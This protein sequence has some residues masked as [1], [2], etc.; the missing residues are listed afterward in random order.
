[1]T[2]GG[3]TLDTDDVA[4][5]SLGGDPEAIDRNA[6]NAFTLDLS[7]RGENVSIEVADIAGSIDAVAKFV[8][9]QL[10]RFNHLT[11]IASMMADEMQ[12][13]DNASQ[14]ASQVARDSAAQGENS[15]TAV[16]KAVTEIR[17]LVE[18][19]SGIE[20]RLESLEQSLKGVT[21]IADGIQGIA[22]QT[23][24]LA[25]NATIEAA[26]AG[27]AGKGF[28]VV[29]SEV[30]TLA[31]QTADATEEINRTITELTQQI[32]GLIEEST[33]TLDKAHSV[34][35]GV[36]VIDT[37]VE[38]FA[39]AFHQVEGQVDNIK[40]AAAENR[41]RC[42]E[43]IS[44]INQLV[45]GV[46]TTNQDLEQADQQILGVL[47]QTES[48]I[49]IISASGF[50]T[51]DS[52][53]ISIVRER[54][55]MIS[56]AFNTGVSNGEI[57]L[58]QLFD[59]DYQPIA[60][61]D[62]EQFV[63]KFVAFTDKVLPAIQEPVLQENEAIIFCAPVDRNAYLPTHNKKF[64]QPQGDDPLWNNANSRNRRMF[65]DRTGL[66]AGQNTKPFL[67]QTYRRDM[68]GGQ[69][70]MMKDLSAPIIVQGRHWGGLRMGY[71]MLG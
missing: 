67:L 31:R 5:D 47:D 61:S 19:V 64:S 38:G 62:P 34:N 52:H 3:T 48:L 28:A 32:G 40:S 18:A 65:N 17:D 49:D 44:E 1:M 6:V 41:A 63:T 24:L 7:K 26:R 39:S 23:N 57:T 42:D 50:E 56:D 60:G 45:D 2:N 59:E 25:L 16:H 15:R 46:A 21:K 36:E 68:G 66:R 53:M 30:K 43:V 55:K 58:D 35:N 29:A 70:V 33:Q 12:S 11:Q 14:E 69:F 37:A 8:A 10:D 27:E 51:I 20:Q 71:K 13:I 22:S 9:M 4:A 54:A